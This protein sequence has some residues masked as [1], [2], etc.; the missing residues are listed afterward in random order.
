MLVNFLNIL[1]IHH[2]ILAT[3]LKLFLLI[4]LP[5]IHITLPRLTLDNKPQQMQPLLQINSRSD[6]KSVKKWRLEINSSPS[7]FQWS[8]KPSPKQLQRP[9]NKSTFPSSKALGIVFMVS[10]SPLLSHIFA[11][12]WTFFEIFFLLFL[13]CFFSV[14][15]FAS[16][17]NSLFS[18]FHAHRRTEIWS[19]QRERNKKP[20]SNHPV[21]RRIKDFEANVRTQMFP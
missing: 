1:K 16:D 11:S 2:K 19:R 18:S 8:P 20:V 21:P 9:L 14:L 10:F 3:S 17:P 15:S 12:H 5:L 4:S 6:W 13:L 7:C